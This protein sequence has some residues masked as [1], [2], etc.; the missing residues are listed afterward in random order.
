M[1]AWLKCYSNICGIVDLGHN[2]HR[3]RVTEQVTYEMKMTSH[4]YCT[5]KTINRVN[6]GKETGKRIGV[7]F[8]TALRHNNNTTPV[9]TVQNM[10]ASSITTKLLHIV[11]LLSTINLK[12]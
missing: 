2:S 6:R 10:L 9:Y 3:H 7:Q 11:K 8:S 12:F 4:I 5:Q 1:T